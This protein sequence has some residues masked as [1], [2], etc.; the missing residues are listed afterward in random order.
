MTDATTLAEL[1]NSFGAL[2]PVGHV[3]L[4]LP[5]RLQRDTVQQ[6]LRDDGWPA[7]GTQPFEPAQAEQELQHLVDGASG[8]AGFGYEITLMRRYLELAKKGASWLLV[9]VDGDD[10]AARVGHTARLY[11]ALS[12]VHYRTLTVE[13]LL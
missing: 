5:S 13:D 11:G 12:A 3:L 7:D 8:L 4:A 1:P 6:A 10:E 9:R 2:K